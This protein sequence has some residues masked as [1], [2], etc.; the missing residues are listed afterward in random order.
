[1]QRTWSIIVT[2][3]TTF[4]L[5]A[6]AFA[7]EF[8][9]CCQ[10]NG[11]TGCDDPGCE[12]EVCLIDSF[13]CDF[14]WDSVCADIA[15]DECAVCGG[16]SSCCLIGPEP[17]CDVPDCE[18]AVCAEFAACCDVA[19]GEQGPIQS[20][21]CVDLA[22]QLC[23]DL[24]DTVGESCGSSG[25]GT[26]CEKNDTP[27]CDDPACCENVCFGD[28]DDPLYPPDSYCCLIEWDSLCAQKAT[29]NPNCQ[30]DSVPMDCCVNNDSFPGCDNPVCEE[31][32][33]AI[34]PFCCMFGWVPFC[35]DNAE[36]DCQEE[37]D[38]DVFIPDCPPSTFDCCAPAFDGPGCEDK[39]CCNAVCAQDPFCCDVAWD[40]SCADAANEMCAVC[41][42]QDCPGSFISAV[43]IDGTVDAR[44]PF[45]PSGGQIQGIGT[46]VESITIMLTESGASASCFTIC[47][48]DDGGLVDNAVVNVTDNNNGSYDIVLLRAITPNAATTISYNG[49]VVATYHYHPANVNADSTAGAGDVLFLVDVINGVQSA[50]YGLYSADVDRSGVI[51]AADVLRTVDLLNGV[52]ALPV[53]LLTPLPDAEACE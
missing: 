30:C 25:A 15:A 33:C 35:V 43:P 44:Q 4:S 6:T 52:D 16:Q 31:C 51:A 9:N 34:N 48:T 18:A 17:G 10:A 3:V 23:G 47:E 32:V 26:C 19:W 27:G 8:S 11:G 36:F 13:C 40:F 24:C 53:Q 7:G 14:E 39:E 29:D 21:M 42:A 50:P 22:I 5:S 38:C 49:S 28:P 20:G 12:A 45:P 37:C 2:I 41:Q 1:M 46:P